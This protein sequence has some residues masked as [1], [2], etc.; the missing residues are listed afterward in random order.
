LRFVAVD[1]PTHELNANAA[2]AGVGVALLSPSLFRPL[3]TEGLLI[4][5]FPCI[6]SGPA[7]HFALMRTGD[8]RPAPQ[9]FCAWL[10]VQAREVA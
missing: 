7:W 5:P 3:L 6:L 4:A 10:C 8:S 9:H 2:L 1:Y